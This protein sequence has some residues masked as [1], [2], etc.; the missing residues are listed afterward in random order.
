[1]N[2]ILM[3]AADE[4]VDLIRAVAFRLGLVLA[5]MWVI[6]PFLV[7]S[8]FDKLLKINREIAMALQWMVNNWKQEG[9]KPPDQQQSPL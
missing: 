7:V 2:I 1:M 6:F 9:N 4:F 8:R 3:I 5:I